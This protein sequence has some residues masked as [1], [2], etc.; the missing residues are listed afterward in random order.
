M[1]IKPQSKDPFYKVRITYQNCNLNLIMK[2]GAPL[3]IIFDEWNA[4]A[5][6][7]LPKDAPVGKRYIWKLKFGSEL[8]NPIFCHSKY[9]LGFYKDNFIE[10]TPV[11][12]DEEK[13]KTN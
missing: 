8:L 9:G 5:V 7:I 6:G 1:S 4:F 2:P 12:V 3:R 10:A 13:E 11:L